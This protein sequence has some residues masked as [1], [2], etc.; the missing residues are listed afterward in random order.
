MSSNPTQ[1]GVIPYRFKNGEPRIL[2]ITS[3]TSKR[4]IIPKGNIEDD[5]GVPGTAAMEAFEEAGIRG[6]MP[7]ES[8]GTYSHV[9]SPGIDIIE[10]FPLFV[11]EIHDDFPESHVRR[12]R[13]V[14]RSEAQEAV[15]EVGLKELLGSVRFTT[16]R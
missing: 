4:W 16:P 14:T 9:S 1:A 12:R 13:W 2:L 11:E 7:D 10:V 3:R 6:W 15:L 5:L 8:V